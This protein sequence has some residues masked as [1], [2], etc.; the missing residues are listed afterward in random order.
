MSLFLFLKQIIDILYAFHWL[1]YMMVA[2]ALIAL[3]YQVLL[4]RPSVKGNITLMDACVVVLAGLMTYHYLKA[5]QDAYATYVKILSGFLLYFV[6][7]VYYERILECG[8]AL[9]YASYIVI[10]ANLIKRIST[11][12]VHLLQVSNAG[13][14]LYYNDTDLGYALLVAWI[15]LAMYGR[16]SVIKMITLFLTTPYLLLWSDAGVQKVLFLAILVL[17]FVY[18]VE[19]LGVP[20]RTSNTILITAVVGLLTLIGMLLLPVFTGKS[21]G[22]IQIFQ[23]GWISAESLQSRYG[24][25]KGVW[26]EYRQASVKEW[27]LGISLTSAEPM[28][29]QFLKLLYSGGI[30]GVFVVMLYSLGILISG[31]QAR[32]RKT[33]YTALLFAILFLGTGILVNCMEFSQMSW[34]LFLYLGMVVSAYKYTKGNIV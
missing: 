23:G 1:D 28:N 21:N 14:D 12:G 34:Y 20:R 32:D 11:F 3:V 9:A 27:I 2:F 8:D 33:Y 22:V 5:P 4:V 25:W 13:G 18:C 24:C 6:G 15:F 10:Y 19:K 26:E 16:N 31:I 7:R 29:N 30:L 17:I